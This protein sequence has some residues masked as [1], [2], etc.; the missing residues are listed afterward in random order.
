MKELVGSIQRSELEVMRVLWEAGEPLPLMEIRRVLSARCG[1]EDSTVKT[2]LKRL[3]E[4][5]AVTLEKRGVYSAA[6]SEEEYDRWSA[7]AFVKR[8]FAGSAKKLV[9]TLVSDGELDEEDIA[10]L[11]Q[12]FRGGEKH[13]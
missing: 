11:S 1:W 9:A 5:G 10:E 12:M 3:Q 13:E 8:I 6:V 7:H 2:L 4:K